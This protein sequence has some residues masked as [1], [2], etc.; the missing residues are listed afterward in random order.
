[1]A[2]LH[3]FVVD[4]SSGVNVFIHVCMC[5]GHVYSSCMTVP[6]CFRSSYKNIIYVIN[7]LQHDLLVVSES[8][9]S[10]SLILSTMEK[11]HVIITTVIIVNQ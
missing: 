2:I 3:C 5:V 6:I 9:E 1:M 10:L 8:A 4:L 7:Y 11:R